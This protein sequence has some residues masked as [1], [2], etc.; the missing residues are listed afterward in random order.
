MG[1][2]VL[3]HSRGVCLMD[4]GISVHL[5]DGLPDSDPVTVITDCA[6]WDDGYTES[7]RTVYGEETAWTPHAP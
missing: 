7:T 3:A 5:M 1:K 2:P 6:G 4:H